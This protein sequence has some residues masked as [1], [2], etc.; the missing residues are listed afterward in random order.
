LQAA[1]ISALRR[2][3]VETKSVEPAESELYFADVSSC[4]GGP[5]SSVYDEPNNPAAPENPHYSSIPSPSR[6]RALFPERLAPDA[7]YEARQ[8]QQGEEEGPLRDSDATID[9]GV[10]SGSEAA[11]Q[12]RLRPTLRSV[13]QLMTTRS[14]NV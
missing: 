3:C 9:S 1:G 7:Q 5:D 13:D 14:V 11:L 8:G 4:N 2:H 12:S 6:P 10:H